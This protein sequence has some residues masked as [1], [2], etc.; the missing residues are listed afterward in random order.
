MTDSTQFAALDGEKYI[1]LETFRKSGVGVR[2]PVWFAPIA[3]E[4]GQRTL[5]VYCGADSG[6]V[7][8]IRRNGT[9]RVAPCGISGNVTGPW[10][11]AHGRIVSESVGGAAMR[12]LNEKYRPWKQILDFF[13]RLR[14]GTGRAVIAIDPVQLP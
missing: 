5:Y 6:K 12:V 4:N 2:T 9:I 1:S 14:P 11:E 10:I 13:R 8:R 3:A 7:K